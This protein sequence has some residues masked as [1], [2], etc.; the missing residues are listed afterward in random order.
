MNGDTIDTSSLLLARGVGGY[1]GFGGYGYGYGPGTGAFASPSSNAV[2]INAHREATAAGFENLLDQNQFAA[3]NRAISE[4][5][6]RNQDSIV[7]SEFRNG[8]RLRD[9]ERL[10][11]DG[12]KEAAQCC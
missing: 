12:Q 2:R 5:C 3:T 10:I 6:S 7:N 11:V 8:D 4:S 9:L 1:G